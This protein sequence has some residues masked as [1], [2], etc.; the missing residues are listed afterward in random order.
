MRRLE[1]SEDGGTW[2]QITTSTNNVRLSASANFADGDA[3]TSRLTAVGTFMAGQGKD[4]GSDTSSIS[5]TNAFYTEDEYSLILQPDAAGH[6]YTF[7]ITNEGSA[8]NTYTVTP[9]INTPD[10]TPPVASSFNPAASF[11]IKTATPN[12]YY[13]LNEGGDCKASTTNASYAAMSGANCT[14][15]GSTAGSCLMPTLG[16]NGSKT[17][18]FACQDIWGNQDTSGTTDSVTYTLTAS[19]TTANPLLKVKG[20]VKAKGS[21]IFK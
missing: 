11:T 13:S 15:D 2:T 16:S 9:A 5:L 18:Y 4:T 19:S 14:G 3:T 1:F 20:T 6:G 21:T 17:I 10:N 12:I 8:L 7:R